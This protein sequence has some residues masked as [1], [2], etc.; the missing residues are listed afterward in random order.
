[1][2]IRWTRRADCDLDAVAEY[3][4]YENPDAAVGA[5]L[6]IVENVEHLADHPHLGRPG[7]IPDTRELIVSGTPYIVPYR[8]REGVVEILRVLH[9]SMRW[10]ESM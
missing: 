8:V 4:G 1:L 6:R 7:R 3:V 9:G 2:R 10:P 5:V